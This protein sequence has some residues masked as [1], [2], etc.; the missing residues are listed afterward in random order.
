V[1]CP[2]IGYILAGTKKIQQ[3][4]C[5]PGVLEKYLDERSCALLRETFMAHHSFVKVGFSHRFVD[6][7]YKVDC[8]VMGFQMTSLED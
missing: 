6:K 5:K 2:T 4:L 3:T 1:K 7:D 8:Q